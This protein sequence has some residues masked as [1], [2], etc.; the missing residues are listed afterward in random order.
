M[1][2]EDLLA[3]IRET[4]GCAV[5]GGMYNK[6]RR[7][8]DW[9]R[10]DVDGFHSYLENAAFGH[11]VRR[12]MYGMRMAKK[13]C[14]DWAALLLNDRTEIRLGD[15]GA[16]AWL[17]RVLTEGDWWR[18][19]NYLIE[20]AFAVGTGACLIRVDGVRKQE[21]KNAGSDDSATEDAELLRGAVPDCTGIHGWSKEGNPV[22]I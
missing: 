12:R 7:W 10:G 20:R 21:W 18:R 4:Y 9:W 3:R 15:D 17:A 6:I 22:R 2:R 11:P 8:E 13:V 14:E 5:S 1:I 19:S 16:E